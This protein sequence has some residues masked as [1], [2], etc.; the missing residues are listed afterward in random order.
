MVYGYFY[1]QMATLSCCNKD[2]M[3]P[4]AKN[5]HYMTLYRE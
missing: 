2:Y 1:T 5:T 3:A 4:K